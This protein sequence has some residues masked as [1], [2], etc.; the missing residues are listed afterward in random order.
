MIEF[1]T[2]IVKYAEHIMRN[3]TEHV[4]QQ[5]FTDYLI[6]NTN[7]AALKYFAEKQ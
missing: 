2:L 6:E 4:S 3:P 7:S 1:T 5:A